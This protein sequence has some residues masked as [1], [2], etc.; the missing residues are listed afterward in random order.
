MLQDVPA[1]EAV[2]GLRVGEGGEA[3]VLVLPD[4]LLQGHKSDSVSSSKTLIH[5]LI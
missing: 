1:D 5:L 3:G 2:P 4:V